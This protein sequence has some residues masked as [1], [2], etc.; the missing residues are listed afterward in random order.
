MNV[1]GRHTGQVTLGELVAEPM[2]TPLR[3][4]RL[5]KRV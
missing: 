5:A 3:E 1:A 2:G 4:L